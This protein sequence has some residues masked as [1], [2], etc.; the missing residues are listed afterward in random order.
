MDSSTKSN[1]FR[2]AKTANNLTDRA[3]RLQRKAK[4]TNPTTQ[5]FKPCTQRSHQS[6]THFGKLIHSLRNTAELGNVKTTT[7]PTL[8]HHFAAG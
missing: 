7:T 5:R 2:A 3:D 1:T 6:V 4:A 8:D